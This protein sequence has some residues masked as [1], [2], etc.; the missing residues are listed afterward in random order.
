MNQTDWG[1]VRNTNWQTDITYR[2]AIA[3][4]PHYALQT[5][6]E[7]LTI[8]YSVEPSGA[9]YSTFLIDS[10]NVSVGSWLH[11]IINTARRQ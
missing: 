11:F 1:T 5:F 8:S 3:A 9:K 10:D 2:A 4:N 6:D 7:N